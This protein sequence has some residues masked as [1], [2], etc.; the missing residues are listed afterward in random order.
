MQLFDDM[1]LQG[2]Q[3]N[4][5]TYSAVVSACGKCRMPLRA[6]QLFDEM[7]QQGFEPNLITYIAVSSACGKG[8][9]PKGALQLLMRCRSRDSSPTDHLHHRC[10]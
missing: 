2:L 7:Q 1:Q 10:A 4:V 6:L 5:I 9:M 3:P 8:R